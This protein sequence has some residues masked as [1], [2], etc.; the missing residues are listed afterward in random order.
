ME[1]KG[2]TFDTASIDRRDRLDAACAF[3]A[4]A[5]DI[6]SLPKWRDAFHS[7]NEYWRFGT[8]VAGKVVRRA[9]YFIARDRFVTSHYL[10]ARLMLSGRYVA[11][12]DGAIHDFQ[13]DQIVFGQYA[14]NSGGFTGAAAEFWSLAVPIDDVGG[15]DW[16]ARGLRNVCVHTPEGRVLHALFLSVFERLDSSA[17]QSAALLSETVIAL[18]RLLAHGTRGADDASR[19]VYVAAR[20]D[21]MRRYVDAHL[22]DPDLGPAQIAAV[23]GV[24]RASVFRAFESNGGVAQTIVQRR[25]ARAFETLSRAEASRGLVKTVAYASGYDDPAHFC[26]LFRRHLGVS[27]GDVV[28]L[29]PGVS[30]SVSPA[31]PPGHRP[32]KTLAALADVY[33]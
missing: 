26:R 11:I 9:S 7:R 23:F 21:A 30:S 28:A 1:L 15:G 32:S 25:M 18:F 33:R 27:P 5:F 6:R 10:V 4:G 24:S 22:G 31:H 8:C 12:R 14:H 13:P 17:P 20:A 2:R 29:D 19:S 3:F 16:A